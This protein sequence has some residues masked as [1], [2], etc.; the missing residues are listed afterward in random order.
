MKTVRMLLLPVIMVAGSL[1]ATSGMSDSKQAQKLKDLFAL[2]N[3]HCREMS[4][5]QLG[6]YLDVV[7]NEI[8]NAKTKDV[9]SAFEGSLIIEYIKE[10]NCE[11]CQKI[12]SFL[13]GKKQV[14]DILMD[15]FNADELTGREAE[16]LL[17]EENN[18][19]KYDLIVDL[20]TQ[21]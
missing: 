15:Y 16:E 7:G 20:K 11:P 1:V 13:N 9:N 2:G 5:D 4:S 3:M 8:A 18:K 17:K 10:K 21:S 12:G 19:K 6:R 14:N